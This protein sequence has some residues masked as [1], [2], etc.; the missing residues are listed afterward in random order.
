MQKGFFFFFFCTEL[1]GYIMNTEINKIFPGLTSGMHNHMYLDKA[2]APTST[3]TCFS[4]LSTVKVVLEVMLQS[5]WTVEPFGIGRNL[6]SCHPE[7][8]SYCGSFVYRGHL[9]F[10]SS[11]SV[12]NSFLHP[13]CQFSIWWA[14]RKHLITEWISIQHSEVA[15]REQGKGGSGQPT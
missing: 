4:Y 15:W 6:Y 11:D 8:M 12:I 5:S 2:L 9:P 3:S 14:L 13:H 10:S 1:R 7:T